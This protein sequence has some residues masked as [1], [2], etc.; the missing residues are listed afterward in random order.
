MRPPKKIFWLLFA[1]GIVI[2]AAGIYLYFHSYHYYQSRARRIIDESGIEGGLIAHVGFKNEKFT[3]ALHVNDRY[4]VH[5]LSRDMSKIG[6]ARNYIDRKDLYGQ[7]T[8]QQWNNETLPYSDNLVNLLVACKP[9]MVSMEEIMRALS[10]GGVAYVKQDGEWTIWIKPWP[11]N[12]DKWTHNLHGPSNNPVAKDSKVGPPRRLHWQSDPMWCRSHEFVSSFAILVSDGRRIFYVFDDGL[13]GITSPDVPQKWTLYARNAYNGILLWKREMKD[14]DDPRNITYFRNRSRG[15]SGVI[16]RTLVAGNDRLFTTIECH[17]TIKILDPATGETINTIEGTK[18]TEEILLSDGILYARINPGENNGQAGIIA[19]DPETGKILWKKEEDKYNPNSLAVSNG[20]LVYCTDKHLI[21]LSTKTGEQDWKK[22]SDNLSIFSW[23]MGPT[24]IIEGHSVLIKNNEVTEL[25]DLGTGNLIWKN[26]EPRRD[27]PLRA[28]D[29]FVVDS[30]VWHS[31]QG[32]IAGYSLR[33]GK[34]IRSYRPD[35]IFS[36]GHHLRC[37]RAKAT[38]KYIIPQYR[39]VEFVDIDGKFHCQNDWTRGSCG[40]GVVP[41]NGLLYVPPHPC[42]CYAGAKMKGLNAY[43]AASTQEIEKEIQSA[44][45]FS[46]RLVKGPAWQDETLESAK[47]ESLPWPVYRHDHRRTGSTEAQVHGKLSQEWQVHIGANLTPPVAAC[48]KVYVSDKDRN[49]VYAIDIQNGKILWKCPVGGRVD[50]PP[51]LYRDK[52][53]FGSADGWVYCLRSADGELVWRFMAAPSPRLMVYKNRVESPWRVHGSP[54]LHEGIVYLTAGRSSFLDGGLFLYGLDPATGEVIHHTRLDTWA[55]TRVDAEDESFVPAFHMEAANSDILVSEGGYI[56]LGQMKYTPS[57]EKLDPPYRP[58]PADFYKP[59]GAPD[60]VERGS[61]DAYG[62][63]IQGEPVSRNPTYDFVHKETIKQYPR[64]ARIW[65][66]RGH[67]GAREV[68]EHLFATSGFLDD[69]Y[70]HRIYW[71]YSDTWP[72]YYFTNV[73]SKSG[74]LLVIGPEKTYGFNAFNERVGLSP[75]FTPGK[76]NYLIFADDNDNEPVLTEENWGRDKGMGYSRSKPPVWFDWIPVRTRAMVL[77][78]NRLFIAGAPDVIDPEDPMAAF[79]GRKGG[80]LW[81]YN[82]ENGE[83]KEKYSLAYPP[84]FDGMIAVQNRVLVSTT[85]GSL[86]CL[87][88][89]GDL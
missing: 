55:P 70:F 87:R 54:L 31:S 2:I 82:A 59:P 56:Y 33:T 8:V 60:I 38:R 74:Q 16:Q 52:V 51:A 88:G 77:A 11:G 61:S 49:T 84:V 45:D 34:K 1:I 66:L 22:E 12:I 40:F 18:G 5:G 28:L 81:S 30:L 15:I 75:M 65:H 79:E 72:G 10:P 64:L 13:T 26:R 29:A 48:G 67:M 36:V 57:L 71:M 39:G 47:K 53:I 68:G 3:A 19:A 35:S 14:W 42:F 86:Q 41:S 20:C 6:K 23:T 25:R 62:P 78:G 7:V 24:V 50:S 37:Y 21:C 89:D 73:A 27:S 58:G 43:S 69:S 83:Q 63:I 85:D 17:G 80:N 9:D 32:E 76:Q 4:V 46:Q 44:P